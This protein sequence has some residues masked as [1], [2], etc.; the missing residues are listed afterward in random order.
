MHGV[1]WVT[2]TLVQG[3]AAA[4]RL[5]NTGL[6]H[7]CHLACFDSSRRFQHEETTWAVLWWWQAAWR[8]KVW[9]CG[10]GTLGA[11]PLRTSQWSTLWETL[12]SSRVPSPFTSASAAETVAVR[13]RYNYSSLS[14]THN[15]FRVALETLGPM[16]VST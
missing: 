16:S 14:G 4:K 11:A 12:L 8:P 13:K 6:Q 7:C 5:K 15:F 1:L 9:H 2:F 10:H 3:F